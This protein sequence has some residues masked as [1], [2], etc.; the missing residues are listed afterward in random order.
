MAAVVFRLALLTIGMG[1]VEIGLGS[2]LVEHSLTG[3]A[4]VLLIGLPAIVAGSAGFIGPLL[5]R[6]RQKGSTDA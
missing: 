5:G 4:L 2:A 1:A 6:G 3:W